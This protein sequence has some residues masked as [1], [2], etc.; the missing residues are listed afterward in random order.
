MHHFS[1]KESKICWEGL[2]HFPRPHTLLRSRGTPIPT[3]P[4]PRR[5][6]RLDFRHPRN[7]LDR[8]SA[9]DSY[10]NYEESSKRV[11]HLMLINTPL[12]GIEKR[13]RGLSSSIRA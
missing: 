11:I 2:C 4:S 3:H 10:V 1:Y 12:K 5:L 13:S 7:A 8:Q 9:K 6:R